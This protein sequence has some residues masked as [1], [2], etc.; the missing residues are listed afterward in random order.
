MLLLVPPVLCFIPLVFH[1]VYTN[2]NTESASAQG[3]NKAGN[4][5]LGSDLLRYLLFNF[6]EPKQPGG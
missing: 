4:R 5:T 2:R 1:S 3:I 6:L